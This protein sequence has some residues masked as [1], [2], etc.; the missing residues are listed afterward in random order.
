MVMQWNKG[1]TRTFRSYTSM[2]ERVKVVENS[3]WYGMEIEE[4]WVKSFSIF[5]TDLGE[6]PENTTIDRIDNT[7]GYLKDNVRW[8]SPKTQARNR[9]NTKKVIW[10]GQEVVLAELCEELGKDYDLVRGRLKTGVPLSTAINTPKRHSWMKILV[11]GEEVTLRQYCE[12]RGV[13]YGLIRDRLRHGWKL[14]RAVTTPKRKRSK[15]L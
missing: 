10:E 8:A 7:R 14:D 4:E 11:G 5:L 12:L 13:D 9:S 3:P 15:G 2:I 1:V 6:R